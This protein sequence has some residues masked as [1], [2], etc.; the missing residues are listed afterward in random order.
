MRRAGERFG[1]YEVVE[2]IAKGGMGEVYL[3]RDTRLS[4]EVALKT[5]P[6]EQL[7]NPTALARLQSEARAVAALS[8]P[9]IVSILDV[10][11]ESGTPFLVMEMVEGRTLRQILGEER[12]PLRRAVEIAAQIADALAAAHARGVM[13]RDLKPEN[14]IITPA[15]Q[16]KILDFGLAKVVRSFAVSPQDSTVGGIAAPVTAAG[17]VMGTVGYMSPEQVRG[18]PADHRSDQFAFGAILHEMVG[19]LRAFARP[20]AAETLVA[21]LNEAPPPLFMPDVRFAESLQSILDRCL[22]KD[23]EKR[24]DS[25]GDLS[26]EMSRLRAIVV[27][28]PDLPRTHV[29]F[30]KRLPRLWPRLVIAIA[31]ASAIVAG[32]FWGRRPP[33][34]A[35]DQMTFRR[36][37]AWAGRYLADGESIVYAAAW[38]DEPFRL[39]RK[40]PHAHE[41]LPLP[42][43]PPVGIFAVSR[44]S[45]MA[46]ATNVRVVLPGRLIG[47]LSL[48]PTTGA[49]A[50]EIRESV[51][52]ADFGPSGAMALVQCRGG[53][54]VLEYPPGTRLYE[55]TGWMTG[56]R[57]SPDGGRVAVID[58]PLPYDDLG[59]VKVFDRSGACHAIPGT[60]ISTSG[61]GWSPDGEE[62]W[63]AASHGNEP[64]GLHGVRM[65]G[66]SRLLARVAGALSLLDVS[67]AGDALV[68]HEV[69]RISLMAFRPEWEKE[70]D[71]SVLDSSILADLSADGRMILSTE[72]GQGGGKRYSTYF[73][74]APDAAPVRLG[75]GLALSLSPDGRFA[76]ALVPGMPPELVAYPTKSGASFRVASELRG[77]VRSASFFPDGRRI[78]VAAEEPGHAARLYVQKFAEGTPRLV[79]DEELLICHLQGFPI[80]PDGRWI[81]GVAMD[82]KIALYAAEGGATRRIPNIEPGVVPIRWLDDGFSL[83]VYRM[84]EIP[85]RIRRVRLNDGHTED[86]RVI[87]FSDPA[88]VR[89]LAAVRFTPDGQKYAYSYARFLSDLYVVKGID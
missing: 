25:T 84:D 23:P 42:L 57:V 7:A 44:A 85:A 82:E 71:L 16:T 38:N 19:G 64:R 74:R 55:T 49:A 31:I 65:S 62:I 13:H 34:P 2:L 59:F 67:P 86:A 56:P 14:V 47:T 72:I 39:F 35:F 73:R 26:R 51:H 11:Q 83:L 5:L 1:P 58:H 15:G 77:S 9:S 6:E 24:Y 61:V 27:A 53:R 89:G 88:G 50:R 28:S 79:S 76:L 20:T 46:V 41:S 63:I 87:H 4:R 37:T 32:L 60:W 12:L 17:V 22:A 45:E 43:P 40:D 52:G 54:C 3:A 66:E 33:L 75:D 68:A 70:R 78:V 29:P 48:S 80:S 21:I 10:G 8:H 69:R 30:R 36:G 18:A 81:A